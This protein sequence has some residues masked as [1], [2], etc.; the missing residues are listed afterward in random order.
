MTAP[1]MMQ[2]ALASLTS[3]NPKSQ[4]ETMINRAMIG[5]IMAWGFGE[6]G[7]RRIDSSY[8]FG[9]GPVGP[10]S[11]ACGR[12]RPSSVLLHPEPPLGTPPGNTRS[13]PALSGF[14]P[15]FGGDPL[16]G[17]TA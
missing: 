12:D 14:N 5:S 17:G 2:I 11:A 7:A 8:C 15:R 13:P 16:A 3:L 6:I 4:G 10:I 1:T 9:F